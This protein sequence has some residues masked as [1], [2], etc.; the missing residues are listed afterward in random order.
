MVFKNIIA[1]LGVILLST[2]TII[3]DAQYRVG[4]QLCKY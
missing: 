4:S 2:Y 1:P 3:T